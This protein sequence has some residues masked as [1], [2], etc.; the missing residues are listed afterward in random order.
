M[1]PAKQTIPGLDQFLT[2]SLQIDGLPRAPLHS[3]TDAT[4][5]FLE[6]PEITFEAV[7]RLTRAYAGSIS[8]DKKRLRMLK[9]LLPDFNKPGADEWALFIRFMRI[10]CFHKKGGMVAR[11]CWAW[12]F[13]R[14]NEEFPRS[15]LTAFYAQTINRARI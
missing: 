12:S 4:I 10:Q 8:D 6:L 3:E 13:R 15:F 1:F 9:Q 7:E 11:A 14:K 5:A 2:E